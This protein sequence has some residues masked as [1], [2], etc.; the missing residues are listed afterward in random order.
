[1]NSGSLVVDSSFV[2]RLETQRNSIDKQRA[3]VVAEI[4]ERIDAPIHALEVRLKRLKQE[5]AG[6]S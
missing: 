2:E 4:R 3:N 5:E 6:G 1:M